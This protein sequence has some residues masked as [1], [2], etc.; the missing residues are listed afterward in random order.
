MPTIS[1]AVTSSVTTTA[2]RLSTAVTCSP[3]GTI[4]A[5]PGAALQAAGKRRPNSR[6]APRGARPADRDRR[7]RQ[8]VLE[9]QVPADDPGDQLAERGVRVRVGRARDRHR[10]GELGVAQPRQRA[11]DAG[12]QHRQDHG[13]ARVRARGLARDH[14]DAGPDHGSDP[15]RDRGSR[16]RAPAA[17]PW[18]ARAVP[19]CAREAS[20]RRATCGA[21]C[22]R[23][24]PFVAARG[25]DGIVCGP[26]RPP[27]GTKRESA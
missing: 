13:G 4:T 9:D 8:R 7:R 26:K 15:E 19:R 27:R 21:A 11:D 5:V 20:G 12:E 3:P 25:T 1:S 22:L 24:A 18:S 2:G 6:A 10:R 17:A 16:D 23:R 14:E